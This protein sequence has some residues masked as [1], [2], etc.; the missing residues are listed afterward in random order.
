[1][2]EN[3]LHI[4]IV[5][6]I[7]ISLWKIFIKAEYKG[8]YAVIP[9]YNIY[10]IQKIIRKP[11]WW[12]I[13]MLIPYVGIIW[14]VWSTNLLRKTLSKKKVFTFGLIFLPFIFYPILGF[15]NSIY[16]EPNHNKENSSDEIK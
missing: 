16:I 12:I 7:I 3:I 4:I 14:V 2:N 10:I 6:I 9:I 1:M 15:D 8:W 5:I 11:W 13:L